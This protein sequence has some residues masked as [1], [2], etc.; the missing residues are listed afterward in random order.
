MK[1]IALYLA[2]TLLVTSLCTL[3]A[4]TPKKPPLPEESGSLSE[5]GTKEPGEVTTAGAD[6][7]QSPYTGPFPSD[8]GFRVDYIQ[9]DK[10]GSYYGNKDAEEL[11]AMFRPYSMASRERR[12]G[13]ILTPLGAVLWEGRYNSSYLGLYDKRSGKT[14]L[15]CPDPDCTHEFCI[16]Y[17]DVDFFYVGREYIYFASGDL[18]RQSMFRCT[19]D[20]REREFLFSMSSFENDWSMGIYHEEGDILYLTRMIPVAGGDPVETYGVFNCG[21]G[22][23]T[24]IPEAE[25]MTIQGV[26]GGDT[27]WCCK[28][29]NN[30][31]QY[32]RANFAFTEVERAELLEDLLYEPGST[33]RYVRQ[34]TENYIVIARRG[35]QTTSYR[36]EMLYNPK[37][38]EIIEVPEL[39]AGSAV[40]NGI[41]TE[42]YV[43]YTRDLTPEEIEASSLKEFYEY[44]TTDTSSPPFSGIRPGTTTI[45]AD[46]EGGR[47]YRMNL[48]TF[49]EEC[50]L[51]L[52]YNDVPVKLHSFN[53]EGSVCYISYGTYEEYQNLYQPDKVQGEPIHHLIV[54]LGTGELLLLDEDIVYQPTKV[55]P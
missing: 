54:D 21:T 11:R 38:N 24:P 51:A 52:S 35:N 2:A 34:I 23:F 40:M 20:R 49:R 44:E 19:A 50:V 39:P 33:G 3:G 31:Q 30:Q 4:C 6:G 28:T 26:T 55:E 14:P 8:R 29:V 37:T 27:L 17:G 36:L 1:K 45:T 16:W 53:V 41:F 15:L 18:D 12:T 22:E 7:L 42:D 10:T 13:D 46:K 48:H 32:Y 43:Y 5:S 47:L 25:G 9:N